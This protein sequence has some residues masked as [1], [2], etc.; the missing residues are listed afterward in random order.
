[1]LLVAEIGMNYDANWDLAHELIRQAKWAGADIAKFQFG[2][3]CGQGDIN[4]MNAKQR[5]Q[6]KTWCDEEGIEMMASLI[7]DE[8]LDWARELDLPRYK[9]ASRT[10]VDRPDLCKKILADGKPTFVS[11][12]MWNQPEWPFGPPQEGRLHYL[13]CRSKYPTTLSDL[14]G[15]PER[16][17][18]EGF[19]GYSDHCLN[20]SACFLAIARGAACLEKHF[21]MNKA[22]AVIRDHAL[23]AT[24]EEFKLLSL[25]GREMAQMAE[26]RS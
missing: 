22:S 3:R 6:L 2:W 17:E 26:V 25:H 13:Y 8:A 19:Y 7:T 12:G 18:P 15:F 14:T 9:I 5:R 23:S 4:E 20:L 10:V 16:F 24:P 11:L 1:M 21:T